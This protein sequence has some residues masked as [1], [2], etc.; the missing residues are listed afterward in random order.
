M[1]IAIT[2]DG[3][4]AGKS[5]AAFAISQVYKGDVIPLANPIKD[6]AIQMGWNTIKD[7][8]GRKLLQGIGSIGR[9]YNDKCWLKMWLDT[10][11][12]T[13]TDLII[14][15]DLR[16]ENEREYLAKCTNG[17]LHLHIMGRGKSNGH[18]SENTD[19]ITRYPHT[20]ISNRSDVSCT[21]SLFNFER[22]VINEVKDFID[23][24]RSIR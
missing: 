13:N 20:V 9:E 23:T 22:S 14:V 17:L 1:I 12:A 2:G 5:T 7:N 21:G 3:F 10:M 4:G 6:I 19:W 24:N 11:I 18:S 15:D 16:Y 8:E